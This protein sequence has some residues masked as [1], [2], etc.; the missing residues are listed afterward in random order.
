LPF[1]DAGGILRAVT[2]PFAHAMWLT[3]TIVA[4]A[5]RTYWVL[6]VDAA[7]VHDSTRYFHFAKELVSGDGYTARGL[8]TAYWPVGYPAALSL[9]FRL[10]GSSPSSAELLNLLYSAVTV[11]SVQ[12]VSKAVCGSSVAAWFAAMVFALYP[13]DIVFA[14]LMVSELQFAAL[15]MLAIAL[16]LT[17]NGS[18]PRILVAGVLFGLAS[19]TRAHGLLLP[20]VVALFGRDRVWPIGRELA[21]SV[22]LLYLGLA[23]AMT[24]WWVRNA[25]A[26]GAFV[27]VSTNGGVNLWIGNNPSA[28]GGYRFDDAVTAPLRAAIP[29]AWSGGKPEHAFDRKARQMALDYMVAHPRDTIDRWPQKLEL[30]FAKDQTSVNWSKQ[31]S[32]DQKPLIKL[33]RRLTQPFYEALCFAAV[34]GLCLQLT[35]VLKRWLHRSLVAMT[36]CVALF[37]L[38]GFPLW[39]MAIAAAILVGST[40]YVPSTRSPFLSGAI[41]AV[42]C[43]IHM[44]YFGNPR[45]H[46]PLMPWAAICAGTAVGAVVCWMRSVGSRQREA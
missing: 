22:A 27:P 23:L 13:A 12:I 4:I 29:G 36:I 8:P 40:R 20:L 33:M 16:F 41:L 17:S 28:D 10:F 6:H 7:P 19:L 43:G 11:L 37:A 44:I 26:F 38:I 30:L 34:L 46:H 32:S 15:T 24:P 2:R 35:S 1:S 45:F 18:R 25:Y 42:F 5:V 31:V 39:L 21:R 9:A 3:P 14:G